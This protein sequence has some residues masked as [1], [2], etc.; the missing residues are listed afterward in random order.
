MLDLLQL[1]FHIGH[2]PVPED[3]C[4]ICYPEDPAVVIRRVVFDTA[5]DDGPWRMLE[6]VTL[7]PN[8]GPGS[9]TH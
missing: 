1:S 4:L 3:G 2:H 7:R 9:S 8:R 6:D 5:G